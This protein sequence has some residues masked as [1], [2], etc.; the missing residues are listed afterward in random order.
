[1]AKRGK[2]IVIEGHDGTG[3]STQVELLRQRLLKELKIDSIEFH[4]P[5][6]SPISNAI[7][8]V[9]KDGTLKRNPRTNMLLFN[10]ARCET[11]QEYAIPALNSGKYVVAS[12]NWWSTLAY[13]GYGEGL[14]LD[15]I[16]NN[17]LMATDENYLTPDIGI[18]L[19]LKNEIEREKRISKRG[20]LDKPDTFE[21]RNSV[22]Q[23]KV[24]DGYHEIAKEYNI[25]T[26][27]ASKTIEEIAD[28]I[29]SSIK[30][31]IEK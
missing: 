22:F 25:L 31:K 27:D 28:L 18:I 21:S 30:S 23:Q 5:A 4:E 11:W 12:R 13:Q 29:W 9:I 24:N 6:G 16:K 7:R 17:T 2:Y 20:N 8:D 15:L 14:D 1:M 3:K 19:V 10:A 26:I